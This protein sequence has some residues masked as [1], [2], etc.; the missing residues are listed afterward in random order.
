[1]SELL[2][3]KHL[4]F[5]EIEAAAEAAKH[6]GIKSKALGVEHTYSATDEDIAAM[7]TMV[8]AS[9][10]SQMGRAMLPLLAMN[11][12]G[13]W[14]YI[15]HSLSQVQDAAADVYKG[16]AAIIMKKQE[17]ISRIVT[18]EELS[19]ISAIGW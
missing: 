11:N 1:M 12:D 6:A 17:L 14:A 18:A 13:I 7:N 8:V 2:E 19:D 10:L 5:E 16:L 9:S 4:K 15:P 3:A